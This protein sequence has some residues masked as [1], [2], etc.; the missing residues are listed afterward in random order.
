MKRKEAFDKFYDD[1]F[2]SAQGE[3]SPYGYQDVV[4]AFCAGWKA[5]KRK[6]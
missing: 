3:D 6:E 1:T 2:G 4:A 5:A